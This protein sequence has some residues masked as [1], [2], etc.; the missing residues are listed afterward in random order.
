MN[1]ATYSQV[2]GGILINGRVRNFSKFNKRGGLDKRGIEYQP[3][4]Q[5]N[6]LRFIAK[7][8]LISLVD[9]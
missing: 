4:K 1:E 3:L 8:S 7:L 2:D 9:E 6:L 5:K